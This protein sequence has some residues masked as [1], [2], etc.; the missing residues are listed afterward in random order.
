VKNTTGISC[1]LAV[2]VCFSVGLPL[3]VSANV[4]GGSGEPVSPYIQR[5]LPQDNTTVSTLR[6]EEAAGKT[7]NFTNDSGKQVYGRKIGIV[8]SKPGAPLK[9]IDNAFFGTVDGEEVPRRVD[10]SSISQITIVERNSK[11]LTVKLDLFPDISVEELLKTQPTYTDLKDKF[12]RSITI[13][14]PLWSK[15]KAPLALVGTDTGENSPFKIIAQFSE[16]SNGQEID[17]MGAGSYW[18]AIRSVVEDPA[19]PIRI[20]Y[21]K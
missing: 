12:S 19:Y 1:V 3:M 17:F 11:D 13:R 2:A 18:W 21:L 10:F 16:I 9:S 15:D 7:V 5:D 4:G 6:A 14:V 20:H 8:Y